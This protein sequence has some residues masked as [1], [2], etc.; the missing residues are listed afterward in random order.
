[1]DMTRMYVCGRLDSQCARAFTVARTIQD[2]IAEQLKPGTIC[3][4]VY[5]QA[6]QMADDAGLAE[7]FMGP[8]GEQAGFVGHGVGLEL[9]EFPVL[10]PKFDVPL[11]V[12]QTVAVEP[13]FTFAEHGIVGIENTYAVTQEGGEKISVLSDELM[14]ID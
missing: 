8:P 11:Q 7:H 12:G 5:E 13:K 6:L 10:A 9:D 1:V 2:W 4:T 14:E 3:S